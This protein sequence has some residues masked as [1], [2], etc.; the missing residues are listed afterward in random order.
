MRHPLTI[1]VVLAL[2]LL[3]A[4]AAGADGG[5]VRHQ[6][7]AGGWRITVFSSPTPLRSGPV[8]LSVLVQDE[9]GAPVLD[10]A[11]EI[12]LAPDPGW[13]RIAQ[14]MTHG[15]A[16]N[17]MQYAALF[18][19]PEPGVW[20]CAVSIE[21]GGTSATVTFDIEAVPALPRI[22][23]MWPWFTL[24]GVLIVLFVLRERLLARRGTAGRTPPP[25]V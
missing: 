25:T 21:H 10:A 24:P 20:S 19:L 12:V 7:T 8:D 14:S 16:T 22:L 11:I 13:P 1:L 6:E 4:R 2:A 17:K 23:T 15:A 5:L 3:P 9:D 18:E